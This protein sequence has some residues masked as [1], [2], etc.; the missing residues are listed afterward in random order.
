[1]YMI[2]VLFAALTAET[3]FRSRRRQ[4]YLQWNETKTA[5]GRTVLLKGPDAASPAW[6]ST[7]AALDPDGTVFIRIGDVIGGQ[8][9]GVS[10]DPAKTLAKVVLLDADTR[11]ELGSGE[12]GSVI[13]IALDQPKHVILRMAGFCGRT[14]FDG[15]IEPKK[16]YELVAIPSIL[17]KKWELNESDAIDSSW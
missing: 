15:T 8:N 6:G 7:A 13:R 2:A 17:F 1:M 5:A 11:K 14:M 12:I 3:A 10:S 9:A 16:R 4:L